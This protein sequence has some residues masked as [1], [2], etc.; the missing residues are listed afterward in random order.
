MLA[1]EGKKPPENTGLSY[2]VRVGKKIN[3]GM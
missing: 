2:A 1:P 3:V